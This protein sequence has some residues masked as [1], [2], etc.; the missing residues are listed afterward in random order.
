MV[1]WGRKEERGL[2]AY[3]VEAGL[4]RTLARPRQGVVHNNADQVHFFWNSA[5]HLVNIAPTPPTQ[6][7]IVTNYMYSYGAW[8]FVY[9]TSF[10]PPKRPSKVNIIPILI[11][12]NQVI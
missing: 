6:L 3:V 7:H 1:W 11:L 2:K 10:N 9:I 12:K 4:L 8:W 5:D